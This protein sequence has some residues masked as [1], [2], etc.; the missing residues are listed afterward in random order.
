M[1]LFGPSRAERD[2]ELAATITAYLN[3]VTKVKPLGV[4]ISEEGSNGYLTNYVIY[5]FLLE[6][7]DGHRELCSGKD[8]DP[9]INGLLSKID[10]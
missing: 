8:T 9:V 3:S 4:S 2:A 6:F 10:M 1:G 7:T 5:A